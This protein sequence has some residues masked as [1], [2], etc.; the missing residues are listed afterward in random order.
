ME[1]LS[2]AY[3]LTVFGSRGTLFAKVVV[4][5]ESQQNRKA[6]TLLENAYSCGGGKH[7]DSAQS[8]SMRLRRHPDGKH[9]SLLRNFTTAGF[10]AQSISEQSSWWIRRQCL[11]CRRAKNRQNTGLSG[12]AI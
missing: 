12:A 2:I 6:L 5:G 7:N 3:G 8:I 11:H 9:G 10:L 4:C 1:P